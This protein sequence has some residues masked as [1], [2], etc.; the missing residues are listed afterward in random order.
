MTV[1]AWVV[2]KTLRHNPLTPRYGLQISRQTG[3]APGTTAGIPLVVEKL[4]NAGSR[5][6]MLCGGSDS[7]IDHPLLRR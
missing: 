1:R 4:S 3:L 2:L 6:G 7:L 5:C